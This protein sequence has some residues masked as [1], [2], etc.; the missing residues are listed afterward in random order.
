MRK[1]FLVEIMLASLSSLPIECILPVKRLI[2]NF[3]ETVAKAHKP[4]PIFFYSSHPDAQVFSILVL[5]WLEALSSAG[6]FSAII[7]KQ[8]Y[9]WKVD[10]G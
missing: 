7:N 5:I 8:S 2:S 1:L 10:Y 4:V 3:C 6:I 9:I